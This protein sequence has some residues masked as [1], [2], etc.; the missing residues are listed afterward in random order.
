[1]I[2]TDVYFEI[3]K[4]WFPPVTADSAGFYIA[5]VLILYVVLSVFQM[6]IVLILNKSLA[7]RSKPYSRGSGLEA[8]KILIL[9]DSTAV[10]TGANRTQDT[11]AG[12]LAYDFP[13][14]QIINLGVNGSLISNVLKQLEQVKGMKFDMIVI[15]TGG[16]DII[17]FTSFRKVW[18]DLQKIFQ[19]TKVMCEHRVFMMLYLNLGN[20]PLFPRFMQLLLMRRGKRLYEEIR[21]IGTKE[22]VPIIEIFTTEHEN[23]FINNP[24]LYFARDG[25]HPS[26]EG[27]RIWYNRMWRA[28]SERGLY[29][30]RHGTT[31]TGKPIL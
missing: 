1:M 9:G 19:I 31:L 30:S 29:Y 6:L 20:A 22:R 24:R 13:E 26:S 25:V 14:S 28:M 10:G 21:K 11:L 18:R 27:Y 23:D 2:E 4:T 15:S 16:N 3:F 8:R 12:R 7:F 5:L 17:N